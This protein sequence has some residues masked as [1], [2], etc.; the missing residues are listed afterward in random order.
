M[1]I[2]IKCENAPQ[3]S[4]EGILRLQ[5]GHVG[6]EGS[7]SQCVTKGFL[8]Q[9]GRHINYING[10]LMFLILSFLGFH[11]VIYNIH[12]RQVVWAAGLCGACVV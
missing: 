3:S 1:Y 8:V 9:M 12:V 2:P 11:S 10:V 6:M 4:G 5:W 7:F